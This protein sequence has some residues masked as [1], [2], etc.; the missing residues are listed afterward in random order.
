MINVLYATTAPAWADYETPLRRAFDAAGLQVH[1]SQD[2]APEKVDYIVYSPKSALTDFTPYTN[3]KAVLNLWA[4]VEAIVGNTTLTQP[5]CRMVDH[6]LER[7]MVEWVAGH[8]LRHHLDIDYFL[9]RQ[10]G[11]WE[12]MV[13]PLAQDR[14][15][16]I[17]GLGELGRACAKALQQLGFPVTGWSRT[18]KQID[19]ITCLHGTEGLEQALSSA[20]ILVLLLP[21]TEETT[22]LLDASRLAQ[23]PK[24]ATI[25]NPGRGPLIVDEDLIAALDSGQISRA[26]LDVFRAEP[27]PPAHPFWAHP[28]VTVCP[29]IA[30]E[31][32]ASTASEVIAENIRR[33]EAGEDFLFRVDRARG[34]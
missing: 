7:G 12:P 17:L 28:R 15:V 4:G 3:T 30:S 33:G 29:H 11:S 34:Y 6:G 19:G 10:S 9:A 13:P 32:R 31:T 8:T 5:L 2:I 23:L 16:T 27:L 14:P 18:E 24:G 26:T 21:L 1:L 20:Q 25:L 22:D